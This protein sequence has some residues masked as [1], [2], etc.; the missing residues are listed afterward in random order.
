MPKRSSFHWRETTVEVVSFNQWGDWPLKTLP[1]TDPVPLVI[2]NSPVSL[3]IWRPLLKSFSQWSMCPRLCWPFSKMNSINEKDPPFWFIGFFLVAL[4]SHLSPW[5]TSCPLSSPTLHIDTS[6]NDFSEV[7]NRGSDFIDL[8]VGSNLTLVCEGPLIHGNWTEESRQMEWILPEFHPVS[9][10]AFVVLP[11]TVS[12]LT[13]LSF[14]ISATS[15]T[16]A[17]YRITF[18]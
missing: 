11:E 4:I 10:L 5:V 1:E 16:R 7:L 2:V 12:P 17:L 3:L 6:H 9:S 8:R 13:F 15:C 14:D 18:K